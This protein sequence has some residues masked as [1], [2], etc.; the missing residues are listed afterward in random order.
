MICSFDLTS[1]ATLGEKLVFE[2]RRQTDR[3]SVGWTPEVCIKSSIYL[4]R[5]KYA[6]PLLSQTRSKGKHAFNRIT[7]VLQKPCQETNG[8]HRIKFNVINHKP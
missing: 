8:K 4:Y 6:P 2:V 5:P 7:L 1:P 3:D